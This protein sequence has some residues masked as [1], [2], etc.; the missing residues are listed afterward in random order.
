MNKETA[1]ARQEW[2]DKMQ[3]NSEVLEEYYDDA[4]E[5][6]EVLEHFRTALPETRRLKARYLDLKNKA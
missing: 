3:N 4:V 5:L 2:F 6:E 1:V